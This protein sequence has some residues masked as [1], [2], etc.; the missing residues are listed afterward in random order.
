M[1]GQFDDGAADFPGVSGDAR[2]QRAGDAASAAIG[3]DEQVL[4]KHDGAVPAG[5]RAPAAR[6]HADHARAIFGDERAETR[7]GAE[8]VAQPVRRAGADRMRR[9]LA[10]RE[11]PLEPHQVRNIRRFGTPHLKRSRLHVVD[12]CR[13]FGGLMA[14]VTRIPSSHISSNAHAEGGWALTVN[15]SLAGTGG[16]L[17]RVCLPRPNRVNA[18]DDVLHRERCKQNAEQ[19]SQNDISRHADQPA[20]SAREQEGDDAGRRD[21]DH[22]RYQ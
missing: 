16:A 10:F 8:T 12:T 19:A 2:D 7:T 4:E 18:V 11:Q 1:H 21:R 17:A 3:V 9:I 20:D 14:R 6:R 13:L 15:E 5:N 22:N